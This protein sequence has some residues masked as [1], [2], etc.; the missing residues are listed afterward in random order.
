MLNFSETLEKEKVKN[1]AYTSLPKQN[2][3]GG[4]RELGIKVNTDD[5]YTPEWLVKKVLDYYKDIF[6]QYDYIY[7]PFTK[8]DKPIYREVKK[9]YKVLLTPNSCYSKE[10]KLNNFF[11][12]RD[13]KD[14]MKIINNNKVLIFD[15]PPF[16]IQVQIYRFLL[17]KN[18][19]YNKK[20]KQIDFMLFSPT[21]FSINNFNLCWHILGD[22]KLLNNTEK[23]INLSLMSNLFNEIKNTFLIDKKDILA[24]GN[25]QTF[26]KKGFVFKKDKIIKMTNDGH[27]SRK[28]GG[29]MVYDFN[30]D[31]EG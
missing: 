21:L 11:Y 25:I 6:N 22:V 10:L 26:T 20:L 3:K 2:K 29:G 19:L 1:K 9:R 27:K 18:D 15:N 16:S 23:I 14:F 5:Y 28:M 31:G 7:L 13:D 30:D 12:F 17:K 4:V 24:S 8:K